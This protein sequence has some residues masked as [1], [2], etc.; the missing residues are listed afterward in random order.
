MTNTPTITP[1]SDDLVAVLE[2]SEPDTERDFYHA[3]KH[4]PALIARIRATDKDLKEE[5]RDAREISHAWGVSLGELDGARARI[6]ELEAQLAN[7]RGFASELIKSLWLEG[8]YLEVSG[9]SLLQAASSHGLLVRR[10]FSDAIAD[11]VAFAEEFE[12]GDP[13]YFL[14]W[15][16]PP[17]DEGA[18]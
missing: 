4:I 18:G 3:A 2:I 6:A 14:S 9:D 10:T 1:A 11:R 15:E 7:A 13:V 8:G 12:P 5:R 16:A 17:A